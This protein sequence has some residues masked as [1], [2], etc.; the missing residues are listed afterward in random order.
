MLDAEEI[1]FYLSVF[2]GLDLKDIYDILK[3]AHVKKL[4]A[5]D[6]YIEQGATH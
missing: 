2:K 4:A 6:V 3:I 1:S 5:G